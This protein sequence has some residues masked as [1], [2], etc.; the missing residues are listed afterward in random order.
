MT[1]GFPRIVPREAFGPQYQ[2]TYRPQVPEKELGEG[3]MNLTAW[4]LAGIGQVVPNAVGVLDE[5]PGN[6]GNYRVTMNRWTVD[7]DNPPPEPTVVTVGTSATVTFPARM[8]STDGPLRFVPKMALCQRLFLNG[9]SQ[10]AASPLALFSNVRGQDVVFTART[11]AGSPGLIGDASIL[12][13][14]WGDTQ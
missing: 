8:Q 2:N 14:V 11:M 10:L 12:F 13:M 7:M 1:F 4:Q 3:E 9:A 6:A 5:D